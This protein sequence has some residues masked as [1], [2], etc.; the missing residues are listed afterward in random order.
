VLDALPLPDAV[1]PFRFILVD[2]YDRIWVR[3]SHADDTAPTA[4]NVYGFDGSPLARV[5]TP[6][7]FEMQHIGEDFLL[8]RTHDEMNVEHIRLYRLSGLAVGRRPSAVAGAAAMPPARTPPSEEALR[9]LRSVLRNMMTQQEI[10][11]SN[12]ANGY[13]YASSIDQLTLPEE[14]TGLVINILA[15]GPAGWS[16]IILH[17]AEGFTCGVAQGTVGPIG[18]TP[19]IVLCP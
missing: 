9:Q 11:Y 7:G 10:F 1:S 14:T 17:E 4:W 8:G 16:A 2:G 6:A 19:G 15:A 12:A 5:T 13:R 18:W 3:D